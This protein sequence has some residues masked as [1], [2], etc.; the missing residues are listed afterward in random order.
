MKKILF[1]IISCLLLVSCVQKAYKQTVIYTVKVPDSNS[2]TSVGVRGD[3]KPLSWDQ[4]T[5]LSKIDGYNLY[6]VKI[7]YITGYK[8]AEVKFT[9]NG[10]YELQNMPN[11][12]VEFN[13]SG[14]T[15]Y[16]AVFNQ[17]KK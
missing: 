11:R 17:E 15:Y 7:T 8:F 1:L 9:I 16:N 12:K 4:D 13:D 10:E 2:I 6:Q 14:I 3:N 5:Q